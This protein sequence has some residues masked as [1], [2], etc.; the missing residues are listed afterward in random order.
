[1]ESRHRIRTDGQANG[2]WTLGKNAA[3]TIY[4]L[5]IIMAGISLTLVLVYAYMLPSGAC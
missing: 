1:M 4:R 3:V 5:N 2:P